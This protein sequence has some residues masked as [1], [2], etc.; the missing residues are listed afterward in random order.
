MRSTVVALFLCG[1]VATA[2]VPPFRA[3][4]AFAQTK[5]DFSG[6]WAFATDLQ[7]SG[8]RPAGG[9]GPQITI[10]HEGDVFAVTLAYP[11]GKVP[12]PYK[13]DGAEM[14]SRVP[15][16]LCLGDSTAVWVATRDGDSVV[17][18]MTGSIAPGATTVSKREV[19]ATFKL[20]SPDVLELKMDIPSGAGKPP[21]TTTAL[22]KKTGPPGMKPTPPSAAPVAA[23]LAQAEW[24][25]GTWVGTTGTSAS[26]ERWTPGGGGSMLAVARTLRDGIMTSFEFL[27]IVERNG[28]LVYTAMPNGR[29]PATDFTLTKFDANNLTFENPAH[30][31]PKMIRYTLAADGTLEA[32]VSGTDQQK[33]QI[34]RFKR[35]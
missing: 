12:V 32:V 22:Y 16:G 35:Q 25:A 27:C 8:T 26:E 19:K 28:G 11:S 6:E 1:G 23:K 34:F 4:T 30:D 21:R 9:Y 18:T 33:P 17:T 3:A 7:P 10:W 24:L 2:V 13:L 14:R 31:F 15:G 20:Q 5:A 29:Q